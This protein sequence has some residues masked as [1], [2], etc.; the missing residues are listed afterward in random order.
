MSNFYTPDKI[1]VLLLGL[2]KD[3]ANCVVFSA[4]SMNSATFTKCLESCILANSIIKFD[5]E[6]R[7]NGEKVTIVDSYEGFLNEIYTK[8]D[9]K[10]AEAKTLAEV[11][12]AKKIREIVG[13]DTQPDD[14]NDDEE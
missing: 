3:L 8:Y 5:N 6:K 13:L 9:K 7:I 4:C 1:S 12:K 14:G 10:Q 2:N 11:E